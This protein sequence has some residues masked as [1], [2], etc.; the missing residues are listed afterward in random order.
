[1]NKYTIFIDSDDTLGNCIGEVLK[2]ANAEYGTNY[3]KEDI[4]EWDL[5]NVFPDK[6]MRKYFDEEGFFYSLEPLEGA[7]E[8]TKKLS[9]EGYELMVLTASPINGF[10]DKALWLKKYFPHIPE[11]NL[12]LA[13]KK[14]FI[15]GDIML[16]DGVHNISESICMTPV[17]FNQ[18]WNEDVRNNY[19]RV[20]SWEEFYD[21]V[22]KLY[23]IDR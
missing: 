10:K 22:H 14:E 16:D 17:I 3:T 9:D 23:P 12:I 7:I 2:R 19:L 1:M 13:W 20:S 5:A 18:P 8:Y 6:N 15:K 11:K 4:T 21:L